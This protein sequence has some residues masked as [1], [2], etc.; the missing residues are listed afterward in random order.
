MSAIF[1]ATD[2]STGEIVWIDDL[3]WFEQQGIHDMRGIGSLGEV[4]DLEFVWQPPVTIVFTDMTD[5]G[6]QG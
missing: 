5:L 6:K 2:K 1:K 3:Y 4:W